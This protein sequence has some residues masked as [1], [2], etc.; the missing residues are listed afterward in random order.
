MLAFRISESH[1]LVNSVS[2]AAQRRRGRL[3][4]HREGAC[5][6][7]WAYDRVLMLVGVWDRD[8]ILAQALRQI[9]IVT[10]RIEDISAGKC[11]LKR[12]KR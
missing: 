5:L 2:A 11:I 1:G 4:N 3:S 12:L 7:L 6:G 9:T 10:D 8:G